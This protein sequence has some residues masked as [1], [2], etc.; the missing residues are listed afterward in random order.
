MQNYNTITTRL[1]RTSRKSKDVVQVVSMNR[2]A[3]GF[4]VSEFGL[5]G[6]GFRVSQTIR[7]WYLEI[8]MRMSEGECK[9]SFSIALIRTTR[10]RISV[11]AGA[12]EGSKKGDLIIWNSQTST[13]S[14][15]ETVAASGFGFR[16]SGFGFRISDFGFRI[17]GFGVWG[18]GIRVSDFGIRDSG[19]G[20][21]VSSFGCQV[22]GFGV[23]GYRVSG[24]GFRVSHFVFR[25]SL[26]GCSGFGGGT[27]TL[28]KLVAHYY[29]LS[30]TTSNRKDDVW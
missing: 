17:S 12:T 27:S 14:K 22:S 28:H 13:L 30:R 4:R 7:G 6:F 23:S 11:S 10:R 25:I 16:V 2:H 18:F 3:S 15:P 20:F 26:F 9:S 29:Q 5:R 8:E 1:C 24:F 21:R 19:F